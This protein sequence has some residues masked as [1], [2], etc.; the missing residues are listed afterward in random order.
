MTINKSDRRVRRVMVPERDVL[1]WFC[2]AADHWQ[3]RAVLSLPMI[4]G[5]PGDVRVESVHHEPMAK[6]FWFVIWSASF[7]EFPMGELIPDWNGAAKMQYEKL[8]A[9]NLPTKD[10]ILS[11]LDT[12]GVQCAGSFD[13]KLRWSKSDLAK[14]LADIMEVSATG[15]PPRDPPVIT[16]EACPICSKTMR[17]IAPEQHVRK[18]FVCDDCRHHVCKGDYL[19]NPTAYHEANKHLMDHLPGAGGLPSAEQPPRDSA[20]CPNMGGH[21]SNPPSKPWLD[22]AVIDHVSLHPPDAPEKAKQ[23]IENPPPPMMFIAYG[24]SVDPSE[25]DATFKFFKGK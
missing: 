23:F 25:A 11:A 18:H 4:T 13:D 22:G 6:C 17:P 7:D 5:L 14:D 8:R 12:L 21:F 19:G 2:N 24:E 1:D 16:A 15:S 9:D 20:R 10:I 3:N